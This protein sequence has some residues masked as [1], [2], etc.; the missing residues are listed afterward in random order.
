MEIARLEPTMGLVLTLGNQLGFHSPAGHPT[1]TLNDLLHK[2]NGNPE[3]SK[4]CADS[5]GISDLMHV[6]EPSGQESILIS[7][8]P[9]RW[10]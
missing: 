1:C 4:C 7:W 9:Q 3:V 2:G 6:P 8:E 5:R 10:H